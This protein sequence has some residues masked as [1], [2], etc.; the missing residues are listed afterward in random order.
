MVYLDGQQQFTLNT[1]RRGVV[2]QVAAPEPPTRNHA[3]TH[4]E[5][6]M[7]TIH[8]VQPFDH[9]RGGLMPRLAL[10]FKSGEEA[11]RR[12]GLLADKHSGIVA[13]SMDVDEEGGDY[14]APR[15]LFEAGEV[16]EL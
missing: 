15:V 4:R 6:S 9:V 8:L 13:Y 10:Q 12:A 3:R 11:A 7:E 14:G 1:E 5:R 2:I 16:P